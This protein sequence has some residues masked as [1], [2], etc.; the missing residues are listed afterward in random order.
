[1]GESHTQSIGVFVSN[2]LVKSEPEISLIS[3]EWNAI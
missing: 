2:K 1:M 3:G